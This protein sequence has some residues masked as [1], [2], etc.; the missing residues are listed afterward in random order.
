[1]GDANAKI[2]RETI[3]QPTIGNHSPHESTNE[4]GLRLVDYGDKKY[5]LH[6]QT[7]PLSNLAFPKWTQLQTDRSLFDRRETLLLTS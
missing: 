5:V 7:N 6:A 1:M 4:N 2:G 3:H